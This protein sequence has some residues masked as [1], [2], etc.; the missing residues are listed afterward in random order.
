MIAVVGGG[1][2]GLAIGLELDRLGADYVV[3]EATDRPGGVIRSGEVDGRVLDW[4]P[5]RTRM[6]PDVRDLVQE[7]DLTERLVTAPADLGLYVYHGG[8]LRRVP[9]SL[10]HFLRSDVVSV[11]AKARLLLEPLTAAPGQEERVGDLFRRKLGTEVYEVLVAPLYGGLYAS[12]PADMVVGLSLERTLR[13]LGV[14]RS[15]LLP[16]LRRGGRIRPAPACS[17]EGGMQELPVAMARRLGHRL[18]LATPV[19]GLR[20]EGVGWTVETAE[21]GVDAEHVVVCT[22]ANAA[23]D[24]L[25]PLAPDAG[26]AVRGL[27]YNPLAIV[28]LEADTELRGLGFQVSFTEPD[29]LLRGVTFNDS[30][31]ARRD[32]YTAFLGGARHPEVATM[33]TEELS[34]RATEE[35]ARCT[36]YDASVLSVSMASMPAWDVSWAAIR[37]LELPDGV[38]VAGN[39]WSRP[40]LP[41][42]LSEARAVA[43]ALASTA[44][45]TGADALR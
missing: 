28:H 29:F 36:G 2:T 14:R 3:L 16:F 30:L 32:L 1:I 9:F 11:G 25:E 8:R 15:L 19:V 35:F 20:R 24:L 4:G 13:A 34:R 43:R 6:T 26:A 33:G 21:G 45:P 22:P 42:R 23:G 18:R 17:F 5:Q 38:R 41:G 44:T 7:L 12:D 39:W 27:R 40:G 37:N 10:G 31:F